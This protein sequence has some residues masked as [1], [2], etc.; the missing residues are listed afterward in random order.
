[1][2]SLVRRACFFLG[3]DFF[4][5]AGFR[6]AAD[7]FRS[8]FFPAMREVYQTCRGGTN[9]GDCHKSLGRGM[10]KSRAEQQ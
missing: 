6:L 8:D 10:V 9:T 4:L 3:T 1:L 5:E 7:F 2:G